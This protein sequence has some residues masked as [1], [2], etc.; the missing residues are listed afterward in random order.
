MEANV[1]EQVD[2]VSALNSAQVQSN[3]DGDKSEELYFASSIEKS[4]EAAP[5]KSQGKKL[6][7]M[8]L[9]DVKEGSSSGEIHSSSL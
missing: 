2:F 9:N 8:L 1:S 7:G 6:G 5:Y 3:R 4:N